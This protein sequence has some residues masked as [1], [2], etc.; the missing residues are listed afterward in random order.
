[1]KTV[2]LSLLK[3]DLYTKY[4]SLA[5][6]LI[7]S[8]EPKEILR[9]LDVCHEKSEK[10]LSIEDLIVTLASCYPEKKHTILIKIVESWKNTEYN[11]DLVVSYLEEE[12]KK[13]NAFDIAL[14]GLEYSEG[15]IEYSEFQALLNDTQEPIEE[16]EFKFTTDSLSEL[17]D[18]TIARG[19]LKWR[20]KVLNRLLGPL[21]N[22]SFGFI[23]A[24][25]DTGKTSFLS[26]EIPYMASQ[27]PQGRPVLWIANEEDPNIVKLRCYQSTFSLTEAQLFANLDS[28][29]RQFKAK[30]GGRLLINADS[31]CNN[32]RVIEQLIELHNPGMLV[33]DQLDN[34]EGFKDAEKREVMLGLKYRWAREIALKNQ[35]PVL[36]VTQAAGSGEGKKFLTMNDVEEAKTQKQKHAD[37]I[38]GIGRD[39]DNET[40]R[41]FHTS[42]DKLPLS[43]GKDPSMRHGFGEGVLKGDVARYYDVGYQEERK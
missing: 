25:P 32:R 3:K 35:I 34:V 19:G 43:D 38:L 33:I 5:L 24:R 27:L 28:Y 36:A 21:P 37:Y 6:K 12:R 10:D 14:K 2:L 23:F 26:S 31:D 11:P 42:K 40:M 8:D 7:R 9:A 17:K 1:M 16:S 41:Y 29:E 4:S 22:G 20:L 30:L 39:V 13:S 18:Q 15:R